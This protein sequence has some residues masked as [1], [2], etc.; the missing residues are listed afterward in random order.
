M[1]VPGDEL[2]SIAHG[3]DDHTPMTGRLIA[4]F[5][6]VAVVAGGAGWLLGRGSQPAPPTPPAMRV[7]L[8]I[9]SLVGNA[10]LNDPSAAPRIDGFV[11]VENAPAGSRVVALTWG[12]LANLVPDENNPATVV[13][14]TVVDCAAVLTATTPVPFPTMTADVV[15]ADGTRSVVAVTPLS[16]ARWS[17]VERSCA[18]PTRPAS[19]NSA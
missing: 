15:A 3:D 7:V 5:L 19:T 11:L 14:T 18:D 16:T 8:S 4:G 2:D 13:A 12:G 6:V 17:N 1:P 9:D 10:S